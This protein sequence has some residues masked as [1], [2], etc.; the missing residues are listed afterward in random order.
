MMTTETNVLEDMLEVQNKEK[1]KGV[2]FDYKALN[3]KQHNK[4]S[5]YAL[6]DCGM[7]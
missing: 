5:A 4:N 6:E 2:G 7:V 1:S 3:N